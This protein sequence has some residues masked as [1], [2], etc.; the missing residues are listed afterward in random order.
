MGEW[1]SAK[2]EVWQATQEMW[3][4]GLVTASGGNI[5]IRLAAEDGR[6]LVAVTPTRIPYSE[7]TVEDIVVVDYDLE[8]VDGDGIPSSESL[9]HLGIYQGRPDVGGI[10]HTHSIFASV[11]AVTGEEIPPII[12]EMVMIVGGGVRVA[13]YGFPGTEDLAEKV[14]AALGERQ[15]ALLRNHGLVA[16]G[17]TAKEALRVCQ[18]VERVAQIYVYAKLL[19]KAIPLPY[20]A[21]LSEQAV[22]RMQQESRKNKEGQS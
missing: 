14:C 18:L 1:D 2:T 12:D 10:V 3:Q 6:E 15:A 17:R 19:G 11:A 7:M 20:E 9:M 21:F 5:S 4:L 13:D 8:P 16:V 22:F